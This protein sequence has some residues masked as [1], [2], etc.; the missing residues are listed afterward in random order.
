VRKE[1]IGG[2]HLYYYYRLQFRL[3]AV[4]PAQSCA[5]AV[6]LSLAKCFTGL[7]ASLPDYII[8]YYSG[9]AASGSPSSFGSLCNFL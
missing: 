2:C 3:F 6:T 4:S 7:S 5:L 1:I 8:F 9:Q